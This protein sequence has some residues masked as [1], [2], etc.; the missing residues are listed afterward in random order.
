MWF[1]VLR[2]LIEGSEQTVDV[3]RGGTSIIISPSFRDWRAAAWDMEAAGKAVAIIDYV[4]LYV[5]ERG[6]CSDIFLF[7][8]LC[9]G[10]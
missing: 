4:Q 8:L 2:Q 10:I 9:F 6:K 5:A 7:T 3:W 1:L